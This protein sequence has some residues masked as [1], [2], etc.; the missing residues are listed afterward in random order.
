MRRVLDLAYSLQRKTWRLLR[1]RTR[2]VKVMLFNAGGELMLIRNS[3][4]DSDLF[5]LPGGGIRPFETP[6]RA[7]RREISEEIGCEIEG[8]SAV[9]THFSSAE[10]KRDTI[11]LFTARAAGNAR[12][13]QFEVVEARFFAVDALPASTSPATRRRVEEHLGSRSTDGS[14]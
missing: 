9:S 3:Y 2:G 12:P 1:P 5:A 7:A 14:W 13:D 6:E 11:H 8:L 4:G 10:G